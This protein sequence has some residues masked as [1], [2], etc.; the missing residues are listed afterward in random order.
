MLNV[1]CF[2][3]RHTKH[4]RIITWS[5][6]NHPSFAQ[7]SAVCTKQNQGSEYSMLPSVT[8]HS[9]FT[10]SVMMSVAVSKVGVVFVQLEVKS[11]WTVFLL[12][13]QILAVIKITLS[14]TILFAF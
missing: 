9:S 14:S 3:N 12:S 6:L 4:I 5:Q 1:A 8:T 13:E 10:K 2:V 7:V 11:Q